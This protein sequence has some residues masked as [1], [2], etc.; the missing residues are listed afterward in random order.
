MFVNNQETRKL[1]HSFTESGLNFD[2]YKLLV[3]KLKIYQPVLC[4]LIESIP[5]QVNAV[6]IQCPKELKNFLRCLAKNSPVISFVPMRVT[7]LLRTWSIWSIRNL[8]IMT[9]LKQ[10]A[11]A[12]FDGITSFDQDQIH[13]LTPILKT[14]GAILQETDKPPHSL[15][16]PHTSDPTCF[17]PALSTLYERGNYF[18]CIKL[19]RLFSP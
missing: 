6:L 9:E 5:L 13:H 4:P 1:L 15:G 2:N 12:L 7:H 3:E 18:T 10:S 8:E 16:N 14:I 11:P 19:S 17:F